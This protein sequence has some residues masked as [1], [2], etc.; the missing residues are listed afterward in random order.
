MVNTQ[1]DRIYAERRRAVLT[2]D[3]SPYMIEYAEKTADDIVEVGLDTQVRCS[4][5]PFRLTVMPQLFMLC[6]WTGREF[7]LGIAKCVVRHTVIPARLRF[8]EN[9][10]DCGRQGCS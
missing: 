8:V 1:R 9:A 10:L 7:F 2:K 3:L 4:P 6:S 5:L